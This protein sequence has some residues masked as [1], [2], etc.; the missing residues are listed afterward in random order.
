M[1]KTN[2]IEKY[3]KDGK[4]YFWPSKKEA[5][6]VVFEYLSRDFEKGKKIQKKKSMKFYLNILQ[7]LMWHFSDELCMTVNI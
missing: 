6:D 3:L 2:S 5:R 1:A 7:F 4:V